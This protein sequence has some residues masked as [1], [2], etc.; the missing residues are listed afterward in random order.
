MR[1][2]DSI[3]PN[4]YPDYDPQACL[5]GQTARVPEP[6]G[7]RVAVDLQLGDLARNTFII[8]HDGVVD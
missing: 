5:L 7:E 4:K 6:L 3:R 2:N 1:F 8:L